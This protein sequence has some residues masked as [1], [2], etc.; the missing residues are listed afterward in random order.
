M[1]VME[2]QHSLCIVKLEVVSPPFIIRYNLGCIRLRGCNLF[3]MDR[4]KLN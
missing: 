3:F 4:K 2:M 1:N